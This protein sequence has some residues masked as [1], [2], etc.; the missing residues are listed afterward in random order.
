MTIELLEQ[1]LSCIDEDLIEKHAA[2][3]YELSEQAQRP[4]P[5]ITRRLRVLASC[6]ACLLVACAVGI[7][8]PLVQ[9]RY[10]GS[11]SMNAAAG[12]ALLG[13]SSHYA[14]EAVST[15]AGGTQ[16]PSSPAE[17]DGMTATGADMPI[18]AEDIDS[19]DAY[20]QDLLTLLTK[21]YASSESIGA[22]ETFTVI[23]NGYEHVT[24]NGDGSVT[25]N[26]NYLDLPVINPQGEIV[27]IITV[28]RHNGQLSCQMSHGGPNI[29]KLNTLLQQ[30]AGQDIVMLYVG[31][32]SEA[33]ITPDG[34]IHFLTGSPSGFTEDLDYYSYYRREGNILNS[35]MLK[36]QE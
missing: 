25:Y 5:I 27:A 28:Y 8:I 2:M 30:Y 36:P 29:E 13:D 23:K 31:D 35:D 34:E 22:G 24:V 3:R 33:A 18:T 10:S 7:A 1:A 14:D 26:R 17:S 15:V 12:E 32:F 6:A 16:P 9:P 19:L 11:D 4:R 21:N 20:L